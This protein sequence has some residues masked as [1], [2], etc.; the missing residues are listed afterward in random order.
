MRILAIA[1]FVLCTSAHA[2][3]IASSIGYNYILEDAPILDPAGIISWSA[4]VGFGNEPQNFVD[5]KFSFEIKRTGYS[6]KGG[7]ESVSLYL[8]SIKPITWSITY[9]K[10]MFEVFASISQPFYSCN[11][12]EQRGERYGKVFFENDGVLGYGFRLG[13]NLN[14]H[15]LLALKLDTSL[16]QYENADVF[17]VGGWGLSAQWNF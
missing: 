4:E 14:E 16:I 3:F 12:D 1:L 5:Y 15:L 17:G 7:E 13:Y 10:I 9:K 2:V 8:F 11:M 6:W